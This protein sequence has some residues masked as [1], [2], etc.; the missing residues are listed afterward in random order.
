[1]NTASIPA[2]RGQGSTSQTFRLVRFLALAWLA[3]LPLQRELPAAPSFNTADESRLQR[4]LSEYFAAPTNQQAKWKFSASLDKLLR[5]DEA[6]VRRLAWEAY[7][8]APGHDARRQDFETNQVRFEKHLSPYTVKR[9]GERSTNGWSLV[10][11]MHG[12]GGTRKE[13]NDSQWRHM[14][15]YYRDHPEAGGY[16]YV[17]LRAPNDSWNGFYDVYVYPLIANLIHQFLLFGDVNPN[18]VFLIGYSHGGYGAFA[19][20]PKMPD[21]FAAIHAS[22]SAPTDGE[23]T[24]RTLR[25]TIF[26]AMIGERD[27]MYGRLERCRKFQA[28]IDELRGDRTNAYPVT[29]E[30]IAGQGHGGLPD[31]DRLATLLSANRNPVPRE[32]SWLMTDKVI[33][34]FFWLHTPAPRK[35]LEIEAVCR[36]N[37]LTVTASTN[38][39]AATILLDGR[40]VDFDRPVVLECNGHVSTH[41]IQPSLRVLCET[42]LRRG[43]PNLAFT[44]K[45]DLPLPTGSGLSTNERNWLR[46]LF[47]AGVRS[48]PRP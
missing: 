15:V 28:A 35:K 7:A 42:L 48:V 21:R 6:T 29:V 14:Q 11:A 13:V 3:W 27:T 10:I 39:A 47:K 44:A 19:I 31:R 22:A 9:V 2:L 24:P 17:A 5:V 18:K 40:L 16:L 43:D 41:K 34:D 32:L 12:G 37:R 36:T 4:A 45:L 23:T 26:T 1:M 38:L 30:I 8:A 20:G 25:N 33:E 46:R